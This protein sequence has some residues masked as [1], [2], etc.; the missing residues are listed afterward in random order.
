MPAT[1]QLHFHIVRGQANLHDIAES[2]ISN[3]NKRKKVQ[4]KLINHC[5]MQADQEANN[6]NH[7]RADQ[8]ILQKQAAGPE[9]EKEQEDAAALL[10]H[11]QQAD[12]DQQQQS[13]SAVDRMSDIDRHADNGYG[14]SGDDARPMSVDGGMLQ[15]SPALFVA[16]GEN[17][18]SSDGSA[19]YF[20]GDSDLTAEPIMGRPC[21][22]EDNDAARSSNSGSASSAPFSKPKNSLTHQSH[23][24]ACHNS[25]GPGA[26]YSLTL[27][28]L[29]NERTN[30]VNEEVGY[31]SQRAN[32]SNLVQFPST[33]TTSASC[34]CKDPQTLNT[35]ASPELMRMVHTDSIMGRSSLPSE[36]ANSSSNLTDSWLELRLGLISRD[37]RGDQSTRL[38]S[39][40]K[41]QMPALG[42]RCIDESVKDEERKWRKSEYSDHQQYACAA[43]ERDQ[44]V[45]LQLLPEE[46]DPANVRISEAPC[47]FA[48]AGNSIMM[49]TLMQRSAVQS[50]PIAAN[51]SG[52]CPES[53]PSANYNPPMTTSSVMVDNGCE[54]PFDMSS[55]HRLITRGAACGHHLVPN[56][57]RDPNIA[58]SSQYLDQFLHL[59]HGSN[60]NQRPSA[61]L[62]A[63]SARTNA[64]NNLQ[65]A[66]RWT[67]N[68]S[69]QAP[70]LMV[71]QSTPVN[72]RTIS[73]QQP[74]EG[75][76]PTP[77]VQGWPPAAG[78]SASQT[79]LPSSDHG[80]PWSASSIYNSH[81]TPVQA[82]A[83]NNMTW[84]GLLRSM[85]NE[86]LLL[87]HAHSGRTS[88]QPN[89][90][91][92]FDDR[93]NIGMGGPGVIRR[94]QTMYPAAV[95]CARSVLEP[96]TAAHISNYASSAPQYRLRLASSA[97]RR[98]N[99]FWFSLQEAH[100]FPEET[101]QLSNDHCTQKIYIRIRDG[102]M[103]VSVVK[104]YLIKKLGSAGSHNHY[105][106]DEVDIT[107]RGQVLSPSLT[108]QH[109]HDTI[110]F[111]KDVDVKALRFQYATSHK[112]DL[113]S[114]IMALCYQRHH[115]SQTLTLNL[116]K[117]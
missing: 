41:L 6:I 46:R 34:R 35:T 62:L 9:L 2:N 56:Q 37:D 42:Q 114:R 106:P 48:S 30:G 86:P 112:N 80:R 61:Q 73:A 81:M 75:Y 17:S 99:D 39:G 84:Q 14:D 20:S 100:P 4:N 26:P 78:R 40:I 105:N 19:A 97:A 50:P 23:A 94:R 104:N 98:S 71:A 116:L 65:E 64:Y 82:Q 43:M 115:R 91:H 29:V 95:S 79:G 3:S 109:V 45:T 22:T 15:Q 54:T 47:N 55:F 51:I 85:A 60:Q 102:K 59:T 16:A 10:K 113:Q 52:L 58:A 74:A 83:Q 76:R 101:D 96:S 12:A 110:W 8:L 28:I 92:S 67:P 38:Q 89:I 87:Q 13:A 70:N 72:N 57:I 21:K 32:T 90:L 117:I 36:C 53:R 33:S 11:M 88:V 93:A 68:S 49:P 108:I 77:S 69:D 24:A 44:R 63:G 1:Q 103:Q 7:A 25:E 111:N 18:G 66:G 31:A 27:A 107:C 5:N